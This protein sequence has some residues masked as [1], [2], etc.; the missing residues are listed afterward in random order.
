MMCLLGRFSTIHTCTSHNSVAA[1]SLEHVLCVRRFLEVA[2]TLTGSDS[3]SSA[4]FVVA[5]F[6]KPGIMA[7]TSGGTVLYVSHAKVVVAAMRRLLTQHFL[8]PS[9]RRPVPLA[10][11]P[12]HNVSPAS[13]VI[14]AASRIIPNYKDHY[15]VG[16][17]SGGSF[18]CQG[19]PSPPSITSERGTCWEAALAR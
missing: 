10:A 13:S 9:G 12:P 3:S 18:E 11:L 14:S 4:D 16:K 2:T 1:T 19:I 5:T 6:N 7:L 15:V 17:P 8:M